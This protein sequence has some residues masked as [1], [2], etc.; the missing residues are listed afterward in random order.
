M[1]K[2]KSQLVYL[3]LPCLKVSKKLT[4]QWIL[5][6]FITFTSSLMWVFWCLIKYEHLVQI[7]SSLP[8]HLQMF[9]HIKFCQDGLILVSDLIVNRTTES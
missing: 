4:Q 6:M 7:F 8:R 3:L 5:G 1:Q 9:F 2:G